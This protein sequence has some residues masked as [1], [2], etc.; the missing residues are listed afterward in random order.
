MVIANLINKIIDRV[1]KFIYKIKKKEKENIPVEE[2]K[3]IKRKFSSSFFFFL[4]IIF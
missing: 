1:G 4:F 2:L 3:K